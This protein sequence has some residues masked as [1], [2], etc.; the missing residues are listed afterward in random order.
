MC[1]YRNMNRK[2]Y[3]GATRVTQSLTTVNIWM[4]FLSPLFPHG[5]KC[6]NTVWTGLSSVVL[7][8]LVLILSFK[9]RE[10]QALSAYEEAAWSQRISWWPV[11]AAGGPQR[12]QAQRP[13]AG[14]N[15]RAFE[16]L[17]SEP[18]SLCPRRCPP[19][20]TGEAPLGGLSQGDNAPPG[21]CPDRRAGAN[22]RS[23]PEHSQGCHLSGAGKELSG[24]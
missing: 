5:D 3:K 22:P 4:H 19:P 18:Q 2:V 6:F 10:S 23:R 17:P 24:L 11:S 7:G 15:G 12:G 8:V 14:P 21:P 16:L 9:P 1:Y 20:A 13:A